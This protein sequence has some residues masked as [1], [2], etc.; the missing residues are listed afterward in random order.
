MGIFGHSSLR[1]VISTQWAVS[2]RLH[3]SAPPQPHALLLAQGMAPREQQELL[4]FELNSTSHE[5]RDNK[6]STEREKAEASETIKPLKSCVG[7][8]RGGEIK[9]VLQSSAEEQREVSAAYSHG[10]APLTHCK[11]ELT[12]V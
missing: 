9:K 5:M 3:L 6:R 10:A 7:L 1:R 12:F 2:A 11:C 4:G 8:L